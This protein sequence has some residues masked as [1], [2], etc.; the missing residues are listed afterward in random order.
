MAGNGGAADEQ[1]LQEALRLSM[2]VNN[3][4]TSG[5][6]PQSAVSAEESV[7]VLAFCIATAM[8]QSLS[9]TVPQE[10]TRTDQS[11]TR[12]PLPPPRKIRCDL[13][14]GTCGFNN[15]TIVFHQLGS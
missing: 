7:K 9:P 13:L 5:T 12:F 15:S 10:P 8:Q 11:G 4:S 2:E 1:E 6:Q 14:G 3:D